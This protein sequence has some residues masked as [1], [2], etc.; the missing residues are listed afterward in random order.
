MD[1]EGAEKPSFKQFL[2]T[3]VLKNV[4]MLSFE[5]H[6]YGSDPKR[7]Y[8]VYLS[9]HELEKQGFRKYYYHIN[10]IKAGF[11]KSKDTGKVRSKFY[12]LYYL[13]IN[14]LS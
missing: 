10:P 2:K 11:S 1:V 9:F 6:L 14:F 12:E 3:S 5:I 13:N 8:D 7:L 4:M